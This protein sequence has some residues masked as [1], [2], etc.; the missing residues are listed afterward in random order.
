M[1]PRHMKPRKKVLQMIKIKRKKSF[2]MIVASVLAIT[3]LGVLFLASQKSCIKGYSTDRYH[4][5]WDDPD[6]YDIWFMGSS[7]MYYSVQPMKLWEDH[8]YTSYDI[9]TP[10]AT[11]PTT[12]WVLMNALERGTPKLVVVDLYHIDMDRKV[13]TMQ[14]KWHC[15]FDA[16]PMSAT[17]ERAINDLFDTPQKKRDFNDPLYIDTGIY[18][19]SIKAKKK[20][21]FP[22]SKGNLL[23]ENVDD[24]SDNLIVPKEE[25]LEGGTVGMVYM[26]KIIDECRKRDIDLLITALPYSG[27]PIKQKGLHS[28]INLAEE[29]GIPALDYSY[30]PNL[31]DYSICFSEDG[32]P[33]AYGGTLITKEIGDYIEA[34]Y[35]IPDHRKNNNRTSDHWNDDHRELDEKYLRRLKK[36]KSLKEC[37]VWLARGDRDVE[38]FIEDEERLDDATRTLIETIPEKKILSSY[39]AAQYARGIRQYDTAIIVKEKGTGKIIYTGFFNDGTKEGV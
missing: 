23:E 12:Y 31:M 17:K 33:N 4:A 30:C 5:F 32:H 1:I 34:N 37:C 16:I 2:Y 25:T 19:K 20:Y 6:Q 28:G 21:H 22:L 38:I 26:R 14:D 39:E 35:N 13:V 36:Q 7:H 15:A 3:L 8:G 9:A 27:Y 18:S 24:I 29:E 10:S 11:I